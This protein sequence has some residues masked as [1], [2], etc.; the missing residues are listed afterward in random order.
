MNT[1]DTFAG[2]GT[3]DYARSVLKDIDGY[4]NLHKGAS[5]LLFVV[6]GMMGVFAFFLTLDII[7]WLEFDVVELWM[8]LSIPY[9]LT[10]LV[11]I[12][13]FFLI[14]STVY[15]MGF[16]DLNS[17]AKARLLSLNLSLNELEQLHRDIEGKEF[18]HKSIFEGVISDLENCCRRT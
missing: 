7:K 16:R 3:T 18:K 6:S 10:F 14:Q 13:S 12:F 15:S 4:K 2:T 5:V 17:V 11:W 9:A 1:K 8:Q